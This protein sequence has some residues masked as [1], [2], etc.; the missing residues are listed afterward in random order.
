MS[1]Y[2][3]EF[4]GRAQL[5]AHG[6]KCGGDDVRV[7][8]STVI[9]DAEKLSI[10]NHVRIDPYCIVTASGG[11]K[12]GSYV[13]ISGH[14]S[15]VGGGGIEVGN[16]CTVSHGSKLF[17][18]S[19]HLGG[20]YMHNPTVPDQ[21]RRPT[22]ARITVQRHVGIC[23]GCVVLPGVTIGE[24]AVIGAL[25]LVRQDIPQWQ[26]WGGIPARLIRNRKRELLE[27]ESLFWRE[28]SGG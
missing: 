28:D 24:G 14:C 19:D 18:V 15:L 1:N 8:V 20:E 10:G 21:Y 26:V 4:L 5:E 9:V 2:N 25:S 23:A 7:H 12:L 3:A 13:H 17:S 11:I 6:V 22:V 27:F 16:F